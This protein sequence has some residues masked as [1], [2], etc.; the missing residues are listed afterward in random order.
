MNERAWERQSRLYIEGAGNSQKLVYTP[1]TKVPSDD[2]LDRS[3][4]DQYLVLSNFTIVRECGAVGIA[5]VAERFPS[6][7]R[8]RGLTFSTP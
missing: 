4:H 1:R 3:L 5:Q 8:A 6:I 2:T 7:Y